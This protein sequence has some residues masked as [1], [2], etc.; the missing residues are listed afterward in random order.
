MSTITLTI[1]GETHPLDVPPM[2]RLL[3]VLR[4]D[5]KLT[6][7]KEGCGEG[8][9]GSCSV[10]MNGELVNSCLVP[11]IQTDGATLITVEGMATDGRLSPIQQCFL[12][13]GGA[14]CGICTPGM[15]LATHHLLQ[16]HP[17]PTEEQIREGLAG[18]L[19]RCTGYMRIFEAV[20]EAA[21][22]V[23]ATSLT[24]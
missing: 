10:L 8:E 2:R 24:T 7:A 4:E 14:Q 16:K 3:D 13:Q 11:V 22:F 15:M 21:N 12:E 5:L 1:N 18:N 23:P 20:R 17:H 6:G 9:C 19:C